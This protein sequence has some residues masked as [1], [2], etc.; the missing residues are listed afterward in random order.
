[1]YAVKKDGTKTDIVNSL[2]WLELN[3]KQKNYVERE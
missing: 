3:V 1:M 2:G